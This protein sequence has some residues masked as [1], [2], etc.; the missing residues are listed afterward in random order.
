MCTLHVGTKAWLPAPVK[1]HVPVLIRRYS[2]CSYKEDDDFETDSDDLIE[3]TGEGVDEQQDNS[4]TIE[5]VLDS[6]LG[7]KGG[8]C[9]GD[10][11]S[12]WLRT[13]T[14]FHCDVVCA[15]FVK[16]WHLWL[17]FFLRAGDQGMYSVCLCDFKIKLEKI[18]CVLLRCDVIA[19][20]FFFFNSEGFVSKSPCENVKLAK[21][22]FG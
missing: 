20:V 21:S 15:V 17:T 7:R 1:V 5:K 4:E 13:C 8:V 10:A 9:L 3:M 18:K 16:C 14:R 19:K 11:G 12:L 22:V 2:S 6:R